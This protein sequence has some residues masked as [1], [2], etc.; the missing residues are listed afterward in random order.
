MGI[1]SYFYKISNHYKHVITS[2]IPKCDRVFLDFNGIIHT[3]CFK[4]RNDVSL[5][6][7]TEDFENELIRRVIMYTKE[8]FEKTSPI[9][10]AHIC[11]DGVAPIPKIKQQRKRRYTS[12]YIKSVL[13]DN[14]YEWDTNAISPGTK[15]M[16]KLGDTISKSFEAQYAPYKIFV[17]G[18]DE[19]G[20]GEHK[21]FDIIQKSQDVNN[22]DIIY[23]LDADLIM[24]SLICKK[25]SIHLLREPQHFNSKLTN[26]FLVLN[27]NKLR[28]SILTYYQHKIQIE[29]YV[30]LCFLLGNDFLPNLTYLTIHNNG[31]EEIT[32]AYIS[33]HDEMQMNIIEL[34][35]DNRF[36]INIHMLSALIEVLASKES[37]EYQ[38]CHQ[39]YYSNRFIY[40]TEKL[41]LENYGVMNKSQHCE[42]MFSNTNWRMNYY[43]RLFGMGVY[44]DTLVSKVTN[45]Y[46]NGLIWNTD[47]YFN[48]MCKNNWYYPYDYSPTILDLSNKLMTDSD[49]LNTW[50]KDTHTDIHITQEMQLLMI[51]PIQSKH[52]LSEKSQNIMTNIETRYMFPS[53]FTF[54][55]YQKNKLHECHPKLPQLNIAALLKSSGEII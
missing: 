14:L 36:Q 19:K 26:D 25:S 43:I 53:S 1:P 9:K 44:V 34:N 41:K 52:L 31:I 33:V 13:H 39:K 40:N 11:I 35:S 50:R 17:S 49:F 12:A 15:F 55:T 47:Y 28:Q 45:S 37:C 23:G 46:L 51:M 29:S 27:V 4:L 22:I 10:E 3:C 30:F 42:K 24:L 8:I 20:E 2:N 6:L 21:I 7:P 32:K 16:K 38:K 48:K 5:T 54:E 18:S